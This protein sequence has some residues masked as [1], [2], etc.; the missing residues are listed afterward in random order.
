M[1]SIP[2]PTAEFRVAV[3]GHQHLS[4]TTTITFVTERFGAELARLRDLHPAGVVALSG[5][6]AGAD[7]LFAEIA[8][9]G[10]LALEVCLAAPDIHDNFSPGPERECFLTLCALSRRVHRL[11]YPTRSTQAYMALGHWLVD[12]CDLLIAAWNGLPAA[13]EGGT[14]DVVAYARTI[15]RPI[16]HV[17]T[18][19]LQVYEVLTPKPTKS[20][21]T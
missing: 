11:A 10:G 18:L 20:S 14:G 15:G 12:S 7:T 21:R 1:W 13:S 2:M 3:T 8:L 16:I 17:H 6:A 19:E 9:R 4:S 5:L